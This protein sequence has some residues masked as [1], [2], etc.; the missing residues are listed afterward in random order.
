MSTIDDMYIDELEDEIKELQKEVK[1][2][3][4][5]HDAV[6][7][8]LHIHGWDWN[9]WRKENGYIDYKGNKA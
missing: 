1:Y 8:Y 6:N 7:V 9:K 3:R 5:A 2:L 4:E